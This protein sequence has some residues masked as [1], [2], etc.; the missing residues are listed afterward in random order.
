MIVCGRK[1]GRIVGGKEVTPY[2][3]PWQIAFVY[4]GLNEP[5]CGGT[6]ISDRHIL[7]AAHC[8]SNWRKY[9]VIV[10]EHNITSLEDGTRHSVCRFVDH[11]S[12]DSNTFEN[13]FSILHLNQPV[14]LGARAVPAC[15]PLTTFRGDYLANK[16]LTV[17]GW[18]KLS[19]GGGS[20]K[21]LHSVDVP[22]MTNEKCNIPELHDE[23]VLDVMLCA[24][25][26]TGGIDACQG[27]S[28]GRSVELP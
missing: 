20:P 12:Y 28:G 16:T 15:L 6:L 17:S 4:R 5:F 9:D 26:A 8:T 2:S 18:G 10:G 23:Q 25:L 1:P 19:E 21:V 7:T 22:G 14:K 27:D 11:P 13:D 3:L 24:G